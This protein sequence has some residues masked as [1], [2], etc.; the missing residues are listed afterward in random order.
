MFRLD[1]PPQWWRWDRWEAPDDG[2]PSPPASSISDVLFIWV[3]EDFLFLCPEFRQRHRSDHHATSAGWVQHM[4]QSDLAI[5]RSVVYFMDNR[6]FNT[7]STSQKGFFLFLAERI[8]SFLV[9]MRSFLFSL[10]KTRRSQMPVWFQLDVQE[11]SHSP[12]S[13]ISTLTGCSKVK[14]MFYRNHFISQMLGTCSIAP[15]PIFP[16][17]FSCSPESQHLVQEI[18]QTL[19]NL[20]TPMTRSWITHALV[21]LKQFFFYINSLT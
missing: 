10:V 4:G 15:F 21:N 7:E 8:V 1:P 3:P 9:F 20:H 6:L 17:I 5:F 16:S 12:A 11:P 19:M 13:S 14:Y 2:T 18:K